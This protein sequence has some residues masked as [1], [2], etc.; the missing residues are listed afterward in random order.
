MIPC[1]KLEILS[2]KL[3]LANI[4]KKSCV[5]L[6]EQTMAKK[7]SS[8]GVQK[9]SFENSIFLFNKNI[10]IFCESVPFKKSDLQPVTAGAPMI[11]HL[12][13]LFS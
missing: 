3:I 7:V 9:K 10:P 5:K 1:G 8:I 12:S 11:Q 13:Y 2:E 6:F 4:F